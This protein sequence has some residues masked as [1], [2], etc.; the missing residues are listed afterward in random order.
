[1]GYNVYCEIT[2][3]FFLVVI[4]IFYQ[5]QY[6]NKNVLNVQFKVLMIMVFFMVALDVASAITLDHFKE[7]PIWV[8]TILNALDF[9]FV[10]ISA[11][12]FLRYVVILSTKT[13]EKPALAFNKK[14]IIVYL[15]SQIANVFGGFYFKIDP[16]KGYIHGQLYYVMIFLNYFIVVEGL[17]VL[18][19]NG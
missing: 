3:L 7:I 17:V 10:A 19:Q 4:Y 15:I 5:I 14:L 6:K 11:F 16:V 18:F 12:Y 8:N 13:K 2:S 9:Q 1:M